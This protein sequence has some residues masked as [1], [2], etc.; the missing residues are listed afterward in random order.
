MEVIKISD[1][2]MVENPNK[3]FTQGSS[4]MQQLIDEKISQTL[5]VS[6][7]HFKSGNR[8][9]WHTHDCEQILYVT[10]GK[11]VVAT[12]KE[13]HVVTPGTIVHIPQGEL[14]LHG[15]TENTSFSHITIT[16]PHKTNF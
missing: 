8:T 9:K 1:V 4:C 15:A 11:G 14:H 6:L 5:Q 3:L 12:E 13:E 16:P 10:D 7:I 2:K